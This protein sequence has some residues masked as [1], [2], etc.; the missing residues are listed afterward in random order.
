[1][2]GLQEPFFVLLKVQATVLY[3]QVEL[4][5]AGNAPHKELPQQSTQD[6][7]SHPVIQTDDSKDPHLCYKS[8][9]ENC[10]IKLGC[11]QEVHL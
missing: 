6:I 7:A 11:T 10:F 9:D 3:K 1:V 4:Q 5:A 2:N 8:Q